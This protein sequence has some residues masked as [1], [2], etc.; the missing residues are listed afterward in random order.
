MGLQ[1]LLTR[2]LDCALP[3]WWGHSF[4]GPK[5]A[6]GKHPMQPHAGGSGSPQS[7]RCCE[8]G[9]VSFIT[10]DITN[11]QELHLHHSWCPQGLGQAGL[12]TGKPL[13]ETHHC[14]DTFV[15]K[16]LEDRFYLFF[17]RDF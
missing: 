8:M 11:P 3:L 1:A 12:G 15:R 9:A 10:Q 14:S 7:G 2:G 6:T 16:G 17:H 5:G 4:W 13:L